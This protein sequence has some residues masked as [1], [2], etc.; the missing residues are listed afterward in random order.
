MS[1]NIR[2]L[3]NVARKQHQILVVDD[4][5]G[6][7]ALLETELGGVFKVFTA[8]SGAEALAIMEKEPIQ[9]VVADQ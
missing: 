2:W 4:D 6:I 5:A 7:V 9:L 8:T 3:P 1:N